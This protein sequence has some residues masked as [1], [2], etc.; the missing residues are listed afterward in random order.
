[1]LVVVSCKYKLQMTV[2][3]AERTSKLKM[4][5][6]LHSTMTLEDMVDWLTAFAKNVMTCFK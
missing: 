4:D 5:V 1:M 2:A 6:L 3:L